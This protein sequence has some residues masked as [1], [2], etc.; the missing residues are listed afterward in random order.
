ML[1]AFDFSAHR[2]L[3]IRVEGSRC[4]GDHVDNPFAPND[5]DHYFLHG[6]I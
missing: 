2:V 5:V 4:E 3:A 6:S 1:K